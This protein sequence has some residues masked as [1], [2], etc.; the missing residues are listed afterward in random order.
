MTAISQPDDVSENWNSYN[1]ATRVPP[2]ELEA[3]RELSDRW[4][5]YNQATRMSPAEPA[6]EPG[7][8]VVSLGIL[9]AALAVVARLAMLA[10]RRAIRTTRLGQAT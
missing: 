2:A 10:A 8:L 5:H 9:A 1:Q 7:W 4:T 6:G 3:Q